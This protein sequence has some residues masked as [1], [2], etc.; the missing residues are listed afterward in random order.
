MLTGGFILVMSCYEELAVLLISPLDVK[1]ISQWLLFHILY[2][3]ES[4][5]T[6]LNN[7]LHVA[8]LWIQSST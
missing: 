1:L 6:C 5:V 8:F 4:D 2:S 7:S 3:Y